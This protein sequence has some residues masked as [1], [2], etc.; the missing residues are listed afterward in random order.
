MY[1]Y[2]EKNTAKHLMYGKEKKN[3]FFSV[4]LATGRQKIVLVQID[5]VIMKCNT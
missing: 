2:K 4:S 1:T 3:P 5:I